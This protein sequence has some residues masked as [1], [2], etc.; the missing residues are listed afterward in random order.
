MMISLLKE[1]HMIKITILGK[2]HG[3]LL[4][5]RL[6]LLDLVVVPLLCSLF[7]RRNYAGELTFRLCLLPFVQSL[8]SHGDVGIGIMLPLAFNI[9]LPSLAPILRPCPLLQLPM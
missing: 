1:S 6:H 7:S 9:S 5:E 2:S 8:V 3:H 4:H